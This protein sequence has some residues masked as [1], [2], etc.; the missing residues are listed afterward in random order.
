MPKWPTRSVRRLDQ[1]VHVSLS[2][3]RPSKKRPQCGLWA[4]PRRDAMSGNRGSNKKGSSGVKPRP[5]SNQV[6]GAVG[7]GADQNLLVG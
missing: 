1:A 2:V 7:S 4:I 5:Y 3:K 6:P